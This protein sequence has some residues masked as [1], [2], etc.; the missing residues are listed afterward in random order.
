MA[1]RKKAESL[2]APDE[3][4]EEQPIVEPPPAPVDL[5]FTGTKGALKIGD[6]AIAQ[7]EKFT[8]RSSHEAADLLKRSDVRD[9][10]PPKT[11]G[12]E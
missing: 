3:L 1:N 2:T 7:G 5:W 8:V 12:K 6:R 11:K 4:V 10:E 9:T